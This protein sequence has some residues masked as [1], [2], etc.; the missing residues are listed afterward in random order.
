MFRWS[1]S[2]TDEAPACYALRAAEYSRYYRNVPRDLFTDEFD[3]AASAER[4]K[5]CHLVAVWDGDTIVGTIRLLL[6]RHPRHPELRSEVADLMDFDW[7]DL[8]QAVGVRPEKLV[9]GEVGKF[10]VPRCRHTRIA[11][12]LV[13]IGAGSIALDLGMHAV[14]AIMSR[15]VERAVRH[16]G[17]FFHRLESAHLR[18]HDSDLNR[19]M[20]RYH[21]YFLPSLGRM[22]LDIDADQLAAADSGTLEMLLAG[23]ADGPVLWWITPAEMANAPFPIPADEEAKS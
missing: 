20:L 11:K 8:A 22:G 18:R 14:V 19:L 15:P 12:W 7:A 13:F 21:D 2:T 9:I 23:S 3:Q 4:E 17:I 16:A 1:I 6:S 5:V 10:A